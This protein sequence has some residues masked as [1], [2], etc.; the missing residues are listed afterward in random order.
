[1]SDIQGRIAFLKNLKCITS[2]LSNMLYLKISYIHLN[3]HV[4]HIK[5]SYRGYHMLSFSFIV[6]QKQ[7]PPIL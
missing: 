2:H 4:I 5:V 3:I 7:I 6:K 1:M